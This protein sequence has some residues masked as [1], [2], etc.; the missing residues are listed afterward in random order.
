MLRSM[1]DLKNYTIGATDGEI[2]HVT[3]FFFDDEDWVIRYLVVE[4]SSWL[5]TRKVLIS[6]YSLLEADWL[7][8][9]LP[10]RISR[11]QVKNSPDIDT[12][13][14]VSRQQE[15][16]YADF[17]GYPYYWGGMG[18]WGDG[19]VVPMVPMGGEGM[20]PTE[21]AKIAAAQHANDDPHLRSCQAV[22][23]Y[24]IHASDGDI[25]HVQ[26]MLVDEDSWALRY[27][28][29]DTTNW[30]GGHQVLVAPKWIESISWADSKVNINLNR[31]AVKDS[32]AFDSTAELNR[33]Y[34]MDLHRH[35]QRSAYWDQEPSRDSAKIH[36]KRDL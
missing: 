4:T 6:P 1:Q 11:N 18:M 15:M 32:P 23:G 24:N 5:M 3:D 17:Y 13:K 7:H 29:V 36:D 31:Q 33:Q 16:R 30:W 22:L 28:V 8:K 27:L 14:P 26:G 12:D 2:G 9:R 20:S 21:V 34:E 19:M 25:G 10:V 35:Y